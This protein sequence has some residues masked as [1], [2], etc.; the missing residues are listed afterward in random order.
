M[1]VDIISIS[2][3]VVAILGAGGHFF[4]EINLNHCSC[5]CIDSNCTEKQL[6]KEIINLDEKISKHK[7]KLEKIKQ[8]K[9]PPHTPLDNI[10]RLSVTEI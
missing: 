4:K 7:V 9:T 5:F 10:S 1:A 6:E 2:A 3:L 8:S